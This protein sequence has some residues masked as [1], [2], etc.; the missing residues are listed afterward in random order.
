MSTKI[1]KLPGSRPPLAIGLRSTRGFSMLEV[2]MAALIL[3]TGVLALGLLQISALK[4]SKN[5]YLR[6]QGVTLAYD[7]TDRMRANA[8]AVAAGS[9]NLTLTGLLPTTPSTALVDLTEWRG[10]VAQTLPQGLGAISYDAAVRVASV[11]IEWQDNSQ[12]ATEDQT[13]SPNTN[14][15]LVV[16]TRL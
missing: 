2:M 7:M 14:S 11:T 6:S 12:E 1:P 15:R 3:S 4:T 13:A 8:P 10:A 5:A 16:R 9:Y